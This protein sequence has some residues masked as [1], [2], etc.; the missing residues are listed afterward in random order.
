MGTIQ[1][2]EEEQNI[3]KSS[4]QK[5]SPKFPTPMDLMNNLVRSKIIQGL[6]TPK[7]FGVSKPKLIECLQ[8][9]CLQI[10]PESLSF[11]FQLLLGIPTKDEEFQKIIIL[12]FLYRTVKILKASEL[13]LSS[14][15]PH[16]SGVQ[17]IIFFD[18][19][20]AH[21]SSKIMSSEMFQEFIQFLRKEQL[22]S[23]LH[24]RH[25]IITPKCARQYLLFCSILEDLYDVS[26]AQN[27]QKRYDTTTTKNMNILS[28]NI[29]DFRQSCPIPDQSLSHH[30]LVLDVYNLFSIIPICVNDLMITD[31]LS[32][33]KLIVNDIFEPILE[34]SSICN[35]ES[36]LLFSLLHGSSLTCMCLLSL[37]LSLDFYLFC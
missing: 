4:F 13:F 12:I 20:R 28:K 6:M 37:L 15:S 21:E 8:N 24:L 31:L 2:A 19:F 23:L 36:A 11:A 5:L 9:V 16:L 22:L 27:T 3:L 35:D 10:P 32:T 29:D 25:F 34:A 1:E 26:F 33:R 7:I 18:V 30:Q 14:V 17:L